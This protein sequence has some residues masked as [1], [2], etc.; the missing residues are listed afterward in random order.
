MMTKLYFNLSYNHYY[1]DDNINAI[2]YAEEGIKHCQKY[3]STYSLA[4]LY[5]RIGISKFKLDDQTYL[6]DLKLSVQAL[7]LTGY[8]DL[9][10][11]FEDVTLK[12]HGIVIDA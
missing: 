9:A 4:A 1:F 8:F 10:K 5:Y 3:H 2:K 11:I 7:H 6:S 12:T